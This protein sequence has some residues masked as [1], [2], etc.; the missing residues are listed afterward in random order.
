[1]TGCT[2][3]CNQGRQCDCVPQ[4]WDEE[5]E[6][7]WLLGLYAVAVVAV[8]VTMPWWPEWIG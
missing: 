7:P 4:M 3:N 2:G 6:S 8:I 1:M 5:R